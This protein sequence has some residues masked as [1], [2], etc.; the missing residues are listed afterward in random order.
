MFTRDINNQWA[1]K[2]V[3]IFVIHT[4]QI[5]YVQLRGGGKD[6]MNKYK[7]KLYKTKTAAA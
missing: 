7:I 2:Y 1:I 4:V 6:R 5:T 3:F